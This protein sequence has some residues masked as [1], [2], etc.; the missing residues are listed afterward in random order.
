MCCGENKSDMAFPNLDLPDS[1]TVTVEAPDGAAFDLS[2][3]S[4]YSEEKDEIGRIFIVH[5]TDQ[6][7]SFTDNFNQT[8]PL[9]DSEAFPLVNPDERYFS[10]QLKCTA[11]EPESDE[12]TDSFRLIVKFNGD[13][14]FDEGNRDRT[15]STQ[16][17]SDESLSDTLENSKNP[18]DIPS[19]FKVGTVINLRTIFSRYNGIS[20]RETSGNVDE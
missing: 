15:F 4:D 10:V 7:S 17:I 2:V 12:N 5:N 20:K 6:K 3:S 13:G 18:D 14:N 9:V 1:V 19:S 11:F 8:F 16:Q